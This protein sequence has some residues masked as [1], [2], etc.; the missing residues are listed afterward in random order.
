MACKAGTAKLCSN[1]SCSLCPW[2]GEGPRG[3]GVRVLG[4][5]MG[6]HAHNNCPKVLVPQLNWYTFAEVRYKNQQ[7]SRYG[8]YKGW[9]GIRPR[10]HL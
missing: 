9:V 2:G 3:E 6:Y 7:L 5:A 4:N 10:Y 8:K 1:Y